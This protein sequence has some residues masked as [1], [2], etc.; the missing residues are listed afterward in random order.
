MKL[1]FFQ[2]VPTSKKNVKNAEYKLWK[3]MAKAT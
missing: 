2:N 1:T 3:F